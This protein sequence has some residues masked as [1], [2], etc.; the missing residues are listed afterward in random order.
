MSKAAAP[1]L[2]PEALP[3]VTEPPSRNG[4]GKRG[5]LLDRRRPGVFVGVDVDVVSA[6]LGHR[7]RND[8]RRE[9]TVRHRFMGA[10]LRTQCERILIGS[11]HAVFGCDVLRGL[12]HRVR[13]ELTLQGRVDETPADRRVEHLGSALERSG[14]LGH[15]QRSAR[16][17]LDTAGHQQVGRS[18][19]DRA[20][21]DD[22]RVHARRAEP[23]DR[24]GRHARVH[25]GEQRRHPSDV[26]VVFAGLVRAPHDDLV[27]C[28][29]RQIGIP[30][31]H[32]RDHER[33]HVVGPHAR[34][35]SAVSADRRAG[36][37][38]DVDGCHEGF[39]RSRNRSM[40]AR[41]SSSSKSRAWAARS[42]EVVAGRCWARASF[43]SSTARHEF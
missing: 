17:R 27:D 8:L 19:S 5:E 14:R 23:V 3:A 31:E 22:H 38:A 35:C 34:Q 20:C 43:V 33:R 16:H 1:S 41:F 39:F 26:A 18:G 37:A 29:R 32:R 42:N 13:S 36:V 24:E 40:R 7:H 4:V 6:S 9:S 2:I 21:R 15:H 25:T 11:G 28:A 10:L 30:P 12:G